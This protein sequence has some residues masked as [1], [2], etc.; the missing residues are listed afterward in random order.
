MIHSAGTGRARAPT[1]SLSLRR[2]SPSLLTA[3]RAT[4]PEMNAA[5][6]AA[7]A[8]HGYIVVKYECSVYIRVRLCACVCVRA[9]AC[10]RA[11]AC[12]QL[13]QPIL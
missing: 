9:C 5:Q 12:V 8:K 6:R 4:A 1:R 2:P 7:F 3:S 13:T 10:V 11:G